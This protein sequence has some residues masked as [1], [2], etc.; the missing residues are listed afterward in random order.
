M[1]RK[2]PPD[3]QAPGAPEWI[4]TFSD[5]VS[6]LVTFFVMLMTF[7]TMEEAEKL[8]PKGFREGAG[9]VIGK[10]RVPTGWDKSPDPL[11]LEFLIRGAPQKHS[12][13]PEGLVDDIAQYGARLAPGHCE[14]DMNALADGLVIRFSKEGAFA[15]R[16]SAVTEE[17]AKSLRNLESVLRH[18]PSVVVFVGHAEEGEGDGPARL[19]LAFSRAHAAAEAFLERGTYPRALVQLEIGRKT[20]RTLTTERSD[21]E[22]RSVQVRIQAPTYARLDALERR[23]GN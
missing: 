6:L 15:R 21:W 1:P 5:M 2:R 19:E 23:A 16:A 14:V 22:E 9:A 18:Y 8:W 3:E 17:L 7:S 10:Q 12:R 13:P 4:V 11:T 20:M